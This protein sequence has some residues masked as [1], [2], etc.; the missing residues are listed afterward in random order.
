M[1]C[2]RLKVETIIIPFRLIPIF[3]CFNLVQSPMSEYG[4]FIWVVDESLI[5]TYESNIK[6]EHTFTV[7]MSTTDWQTKKAEIFLLSFDGKCIHYASIARRNKKVVTGKNRI[8]LTNF[9]HLIP[10][11]RLDEIDNSLSSFVRRYFIKSSVG[12]G[13]RLP[14]KTWSEVT[15]AIKRLRPDISE[16]FDRLYSLMTITPI[17]LNKGGSAILIQE[18]DAVNLSLRIAG[19]DPILLND[20]VPP[21]KE[22]APFLK[23]LKSV[24]L[25]EDQ[26]IINDLDVFGEWERL[27]ESFVGTVRFRKGNEQLTI[28]NVNRLPLEKTMGVDL[29]YYFHKFDSYI[30]VQYKRMLQ[31]RNNTTYRLNDESYKSEISRMNELEQIFSNNLQMSLPKNN[32]PSDYKL[33]QCAFYFKLCPAKITDINS[34]EMIKGMYIPLDYWKIL[35]ASEQTLGAKGGRVMTFENVDRYFNNTLFIDLVQNGWVGSPI[36]D[37]KIITEIIRQAMESG[38]SVILSSLKTIYPEIKQPKAS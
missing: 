33:N 7:A 12:T 10:P 31:E 3:L 36:K 20:Y 22:L 23:S 17:L 11:I 13:E 27:R 6:N 24:T 32:Q 9:V 15:S 1:I 26:M 18:R 37:S 2:F 34:M 16:S 8:Q 14:P 38:R 29:I 35:I 19:F 28:I 25:R 4:G 21:D 5:S 30:L